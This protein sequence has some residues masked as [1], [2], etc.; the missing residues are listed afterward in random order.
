RIILRGMVVSWNAYRAVLDCSR[1]AP[2]N[3]DVMLNTSWWIAE[4][5][6]S[7]ST[8]DYRGR[9]AQLAM[10]R[11]GCHGSD[12]ISSRVL[13]LRSRFLQTVLITL[14]SLAY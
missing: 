8:D 6:T 3:D 9:L 10:F 1:F 5:A 4:L 2:D 7:Y 11:I 14:S 12:H 13:F